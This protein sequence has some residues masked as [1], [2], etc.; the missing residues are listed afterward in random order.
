MSMHLV[1]TVVLV[2]VSQVQGR[3]V[4]RR[5]PCP[6]ATLEMCKSGS[7]YL[8]LS[9]ECCCA[10]KLLV[11]LAGMLCKYLPPSPP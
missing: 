8:R 10:S 6:L 2:H 1:T 5:A 4:T 7:R 9:G 11:S 3:Q